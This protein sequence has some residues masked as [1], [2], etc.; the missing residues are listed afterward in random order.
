MAD[1]PT[2]ALDSN[3]GKQ[4]LDTLKKLSKE[5]LIIVVSH[6]RDFAEIYGDRII[7]LSYGKVISDVT[8]EIK[9]SK[10]ILSN[11]EIINDNIISIK[12]GKEITK[13][14]FD[15]FYSLLKNK[16]GEI[17]I[18]NGEKQIPLMKQVAHISNDNKSEVFN[19]TKDVKLEEYDGSKT[20]FFKS[21]LPFKRA[22]K[23]GSSSLKSKPIR[24]LFPIFLT[25]VSLTMFGVAC[26]LL[27]YD[28]TYSIS[29]GL[30]TS[31]NDYEAPA[32]SYD[33][34]YH[35]DV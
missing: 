25:I 6:D 15:D 20:K 23:M 29:T 31:V 32:K 18:S 24:M 1:E 5:K 35:Q 3:T 10:S 33:R 16:D 26:T 17:L 19:H 2:G 12:N 21:R 4:V 22:F 7:E 30:E 13:E 14:E 8:K 11:V 28:S 27:L 34:M 9:Q